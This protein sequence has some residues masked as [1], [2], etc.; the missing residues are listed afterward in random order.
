MQNIQTTE[1][2]A[3]SFDRLLAG[4]FVGD[5]YAERL[6]LA[7]LGVDQFDGFLG[8]VFMQIDAQYPRAFLRKS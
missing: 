1:S 6:G 7:A 5:I 2:L 3:A 4:V 8:T